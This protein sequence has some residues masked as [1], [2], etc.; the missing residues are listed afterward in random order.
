MELKKNPGSLSTAEVM[1]SEKVNFAGNIHG[2][3]ILEPIDQTAYAS[4]AR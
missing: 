4:A 2:R 3:Y 1:R